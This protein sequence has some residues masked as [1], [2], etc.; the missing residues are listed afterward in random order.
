MR[1]TKYCNGCGVRMQDDNILGLGFTTSLDND[2][3]MRCFRLQ[4]YGDYESVS[5]NLIDYESII[6]G[7]NKTKDLVLYVVDVLNLPDNLRNI[8]ELVH[9]E[10]ILVLNKRDLLPLSVKDEKIIEYL[11]KENL[12]Y[13]DIVIVSSEK[14][15]NM[16]ILLS[17]IKKHQKSKNVYVIGYTNAGKSSLISKFIKNYGDGD[18]SLTIA[19]LPSTTL[20]KIVIPIND[21][22]TLIDT[23]GIIDKDNI[24]NFVD[25]KMYKRLNSKR[26]IRPKT[27]QLSPNESLLIGDLVRIDYQEGVIRNSFTFYIPNEIKIRRCR[28]H[29]NN[30][31]ELANR[32]FDIKYSEDLV[33]RGLG[34]I[35]IVAACNLSIYLNKDVKAFTRKSMI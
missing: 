23:P 32:S 9:N 14:N 31:K 24:I 30:L 19:P 33:I 16:D 22:I 4:N 7:I 29:G 5:S 2:M 18:T 28:F 15:T 21:D 1:K 17:K 34:F 8:Q 25:K 27:Y 10:C 12:G 11:Q 6:S 26:E 20:D 35:K 13:D 3:C